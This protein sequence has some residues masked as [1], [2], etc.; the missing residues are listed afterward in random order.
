VKN[1]QIWRVDEMAITA[2]T[3]MLEECCSKSDFSII[4]KV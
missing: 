1:A 3:K 2:E 4:N